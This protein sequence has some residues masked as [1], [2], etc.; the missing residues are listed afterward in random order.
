MR[1]PC[2]DPCVFHSHTPSSLNLTVLALALAVCFW[3]APSAFSQ[4]QDLSPQFQQSA[5]E[6]R[7]V[8]DDELADARGKLHHCMAELERF[9]RP[10]SSNGQ[11]WL[12]YLRWDDLATALSAEPPHSPALA[13]T[14]RQLNRDENGL[15]LSPFRRVSDALLRYSQ[16]LQLAQQPDQQQ[17]YRSQLE[18]LQTQLNE[19]RNEPSGATAG[20]IGS[21]LGFLA[22]IGRSPEL[23]HAIRSQFALPNAY[24]DV[25]TSLVAA[26]V[27][28]IDRR[29]W[30]T[31]CILGTSIRGDAH[32]IG[33]VGVVSIPSDEKAVLEFVSD[34]RTKSYN[35]GTNGPAVIRSTSHTEFT[36]TKRVEL[37]DPA[38]VA[39]A[40]QARA[41]TDTHFQS[42]A[43]QGGGLG[44]RL[45]SNI[46]WKRARQNE[47][48]AEAIASDH[49][50]D[51]IE[52][53]FDD[54]VNDEIRKARKRYV[55][56][57]R[58]PLERR[59]DVPEH[60]RFHSSAKSLGLEVVQASRS[61]LGA[62]GSPPEAPAGHDMTVRLHESAVNNYSAS[63]LGG[64]T[65]SESEPGQEV[66]FDVKLP[67]WMKDAWENRTLDDA[68]AESDKPFKPWSLRFRE[69][70]PL[71]VAF[72]DGN[73]RL[74]VH[75]SRLKSGDNSFAN[76]D[77][78]A[79]YIPELKNGGVTL[80]R[81]GDLVMLPADFRGSL[82]SR[83][84]AE[85]R[86]LEEELN[87]RA[88]QG[89][90]FRKEIEFEAL[91][92]EGALADAGPLVFNEFDT[93]SGWLT[94]AWDRQQ[95]ES[96]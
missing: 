41:D 55:E 75:I 28:P 40:S 90:G 18:R 77:V 17:Y 12:R 23:V 2:H 91:Q 58:R 16:L 15:E 56:E 54:E 84:A 7:P 31:D 4:P 19:Y 89:R 26:S 63:V 48:R 36:A 32:S 62:A 72:V 80:R 76:W 25:T 74:T 67:K 70:R 64:A 73:V 22:G 87:E 8:S 79:T 38:F 3:I 37:S 57:Y 69:N 95:H 71:T 65:A 6:F 34:G 66:K 13:A 82:S 47:R 60:I 85:R 10:S 78:T 29:E 52:R 94:M 61:Q 83:Q 53:R 81:E 96:R 59:G 24:V 86:N 35:R 21:R 44:S 45:V 93:S 88:A 20:E 50:E 43:K 39:R 11:R 92:P 49:A 51:R 27:E 14:Y 5:D 68:A 9:V 1:T 46:G 42:V 33:S 30:I